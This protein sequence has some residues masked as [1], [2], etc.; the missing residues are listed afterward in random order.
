MGAGYADRARVLRAINSTKCLD[1]M[2][3]LV[4]TTHI[5]KTKGDNMFGFILSVCI[6]FTNCQDYVP[7]VYYSMED[8]RVAAATYNVKHNEAI[9]ECIRIEE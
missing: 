8:C 2:I 5:N 7:E 6:G 9:G 1:N 3:G 4:D